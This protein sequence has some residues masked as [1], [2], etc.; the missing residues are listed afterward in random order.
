MS[1]QWRT[2]SSRLVD[3]IHRL[4]QIRPYFE[5]IIG[6][7]HI[8]R[9]SILAEGFYASMRDTVHCLP[10]LNGARGRSFCRGN[11]GGPNQELCQNSWNAI[12]QLDL[13]PLSGSELLSI[14]GWTA[15]SSHLVL[16]L[17]HQ[18]ENG[19]S[20]RYTCRCWQWRVA[21]SSF[22]AW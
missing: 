14:A 17:K 8:T 21:A 2:C 16:G 11:D 6:A 20:R 3:P 22:H 9:S 1:D 13:Q 15:R 12:S 5:N 7:S 10:V 19:F 4:V 18:L